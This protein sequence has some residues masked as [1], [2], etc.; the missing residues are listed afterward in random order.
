ME[1]TQTRI[2]FIAIGGSAMHNLA[3]ALH[4]KGYQVSGSDDEIY[5]P[6][7]SNL[8]KHG[9]LPEESGWFPDKINKNLDAIILG[10]HARSDNPELNAA[11][12]LG[13]K[14]YSYPEFIY[15]ESIDKQ[16]IVISGSHGKTTI[17]AMIMH[18]LKYHNRQFDYLIGAS[19]EGFDI[20][21]KLTD[22]APIIIIEGDEYLASPIHR[23]PKF[24]IYK[25]H[26]GLMSGIAWDHM[27]VFPTEDV[28]VR[29]FDHFADAT[30]K[31]GILIFNDED[32]VASVICKKERPDVTDVEYIAHKAEVQNGIT[33]LISPSK[34]KF[35]V[36]FFG[37]HNLL[38]VSGA[39]AVLSKIAITE[40]QFYEAI[41]SFKG[42]SLRLE[43]LGSNN[44]TVIFRD[45]AHAPS[46]LEAT[47]E[48]VKSQYPNRRLVACIELHTFSSVNRDFIP[49]YQNTFNTPDKA[50]IFYD[51]SVSEKKKMAPLEVE[52]L[53]KAFNRSDLEIV[54]SPEQ[55]SHLLKQENWANTNL[56][57][58]SSG[59]FHQLN[60]EELTSAILS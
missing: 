10:M 46:K 40:E 56:L 38:N 32:A 42:A 31:A 57:L 8:K 17:T 60:L 21:V 14:I 54:Q 53:K 48:A 55:L 58:M 27:N 16:R 29:Q 2:H 43:K 9:L 50:I 26:I 23:Q 15:N 34:E 6:A 44:Q 5:E 59:N 11:Q 3:I 7:L 52:E 47:T 41:G 37:K 33:Y 13:I 1:K 45:F 28:Y 25:H 18:V 49:N 12:E 20:N 22:E 30:P 19:A 24:L 36:N 39:K 35:K 51:P 4:L